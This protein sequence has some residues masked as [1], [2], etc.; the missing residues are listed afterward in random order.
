MRI[1]TAEF[2]RGDLL[3]LV[4]GAAPDLHAAVLRQLNVRR[5]ALCRPFPAIQGRPTRC[6]LASVPPDPVL[7][8]ARGH[9]ERILVR[10]G[11][12]LEQFRSGPNCAAIGGAYGYRF[13]RAVQSPRPP[14]RSRNLHVAEKRR[15]YVVLVVGADSD[16]DVKRVLQ[17]QA[18]RATRRM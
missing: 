9:Q 2:V 7:A 3:L 12:T 8:R 14:G 4:S 15:F 18:H 1:G 5:A 11:G 6:D 10:P 16:A 17:L 13:Q